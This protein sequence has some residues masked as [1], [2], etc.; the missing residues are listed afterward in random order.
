MNTEE[1]SNTLAFFSA[2][3]YGINPSHP[4]IATARNRLQK[5][6]ADG[7]KVEALGATVRGLADRALDAAAA[8]GDTVTVRSLLALGA[9]AHADPVMRPI[10]FAYRE[11]QRNGHTETVAELAAT[12]MVP[13]WV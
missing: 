9:G 7:A 11:A 13:S 4:A 2:V 5:F 10:V 6:A 3:A 1:L 8:H 12:G